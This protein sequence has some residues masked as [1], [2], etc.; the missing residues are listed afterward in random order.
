MTQSTNGKKSS[1][2]EVEEQNI[3]TYQRIEGKALLTKRT[4]GLVSVLKTQ[5]T[6]L[7]RIWV[8]QH[9]DSYSSERAEW[10]QRAEDGNGIEPEDDSVSV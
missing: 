9:L 8:H 2:A 4:S 10:R 5:P 1:S 6:T 3:W 7:R